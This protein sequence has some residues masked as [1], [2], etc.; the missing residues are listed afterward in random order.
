MS[1]SG[2]DPAGP[3]IASYNV[4]LSADGGRFTL[5][6]SGTTAT[7]AVF[8]GQAGNTYGFYSVA[9]DNVGLVQP[10]PN[11]RRLSLAPA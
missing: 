11:E 3:G 7:S 2:S 8:S 1:W 5:W 10:T 4:Y 9:T 6:Q